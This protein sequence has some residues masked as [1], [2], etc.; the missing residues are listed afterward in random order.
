MT[1]CRQWR[2]A[3]NLVLVLMIVPAMAGAAPVDTF[4]QLS[5]VLR[6]GDIIEIADTSGRRIR[7]RLAEV[8]DCSIAVVLSGTNRA[9]VPRNEVKKI[10]RLRPA[11]SSDIAAAARTCE[12]RDCP[13]LTLMVSSVAGVAHGFGAVFNR[14][15]TVYRAPKES[16]VSNPATCRR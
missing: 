4:K 8:T 9:T 5:N 11:R 2:R 12:I 13:P 15:K 10:R 16:A 14:P 1:P 7:G 3:A 6:A